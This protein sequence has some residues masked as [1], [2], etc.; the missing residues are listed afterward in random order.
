MTDWVLAPVE[1]TDAMIAAGI[2]ERHGADVPEAWSLA[3]ANIYRT[4]IEHRPDAPAL[5]QA[6]LERAARA[7]ML[8]HDC[9]PDVYIGMHGGWGHWLDAARVT[10]MAACEDQGA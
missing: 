8:H 10:I 5:S 1:P 4:M 9:D 7:L 6:Q 3:T 2:I